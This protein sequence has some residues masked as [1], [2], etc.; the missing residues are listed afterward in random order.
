M[1]QMWCTGAAECHQTCE[2]GGCQVTCTDTETCVLDCPG[3][4]CNLTC[5]GGVE[6]CR[7]EGCDDTCALACGGAPDCQNS[8]SPLDGGC[9]TLP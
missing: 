1:C 2:G 8:C 9:I 6:S 4:G 5:L 3:G 7:I